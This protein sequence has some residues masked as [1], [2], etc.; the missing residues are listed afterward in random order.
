MFGENGFLLGR[1]AFSSQSELNQTVLHELYRLTFSQAAE[2]VSGVLATQE[3]NAAA[4][5][6]ARAAGFL[7]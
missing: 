3:T 4:S 7:P 1:E 6:A 5:F 2:G